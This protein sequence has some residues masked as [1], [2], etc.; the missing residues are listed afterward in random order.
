MLIPFFHKAY[1]VDDPIFLNGAAHVLRDPFHP[2]AFTMAWMTTYPAPASLFFSNSPLMFYLLVPVIALGGA[3]WVGHLL[4]LLFFCAGIWGTVSLALRLRLTSREAVWSGVLL[5]ATPA[6]VAMAGTDMPDIPAM[7]LGVLAVD[8][9]TAWKQSGRVL[10]GLLGALLL[11]LAALSRSHAIMLTGVCL[12]WLF[13]PGV[14][15]SWIAGLWLLL[16]PILF[17][18]VLRVTADPTSGG[19]LHATRSFT[20]THFVPSNLLA[21]LTHFVWMIPLTIPWALLSRRLGCIPTVC[22][23][24]ASVVLAA[25]FPHRVALWLAPLAL[26]TAFVLIDIFQ[27]AAGE[28]DW[29]RLFLAAWLLL[30][31]PALGYIHLPS[32]YLVPCAPAAALL[33]VTGL[34]SSTEKFR[35]AILAGTVVAGVLTGLLILRA[36]DNLAGALRQ[37]AAQLIAP[38]SARGERVWFY[39]TWGFYWYAERAGAR[40]LSTVPPLPAAG[41]FI[42]T[43][44]SGKDA[45]TSPGLGARPI[46]HLAVSAPGGRVFGGNPPA[47]FYSNYWGYLPWSWS[48]EPLTTFDVWQAQ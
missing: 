6:V 9:L 22:F 18:L 32:K 48:R 28:R 11:G 17:A 33:V 43:C 20:S 23:A 45:I 47:G 12:I 46:R 37:G 42:V 35:G 5:A 34:R 38:R 26:L 29:T 10:D 31:V 24:G 41:D 40:P 21:F 7:A 8:R 2:T 36:D 16:P 4:M 30:P 13:E 19:I 39:G 27:S 3:E 14:K 44:S 1:T 25:C 15:R